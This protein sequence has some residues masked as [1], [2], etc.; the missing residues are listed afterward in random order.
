MLGPPSTSFY[1]QMQNCSVCAFEM[2]LLLFI[3]FVECMWHT[4]HALHDCETYGTINKILHLTMY[5]HNFVLSLLLGR[6]AIQ[7]HNTQIMPPNLVPWRYSYSSYHYQT[8]FSY[9]IKSPNN[10]MLYGINGNQ[11]GIAAVA[12]IFIYNRTKTQNRAIR[13]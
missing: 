2:F 7:Y 1:Y 11:D 8:L 6:V 13:Y 12:A 5:Y 3:V 10:T 9:I 4:E